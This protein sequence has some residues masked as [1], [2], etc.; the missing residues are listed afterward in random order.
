MSDAQRRKGLG[1][2][3][4]ALIDA[5]A[6]PPPDAESPRGP[7]PTEIAVDLIAPNPDQPRKR[8]DADE[9]EALATSIREKGVIQPLI[10]RPSAQRDGRY[11]IVAGERR[12]R[13]AQMAR[14]HAVPAIVRALDDTETLEIALLE[15]VQRADLDPI[16][17]AAGYAQL[18][19]RYGHTQDRLAA[20]V[21]KSRSHIANTLR[22]LNLPEDVR[23]LLQSGKLTA[24]HARAAL[25][26]EDPGA[27]ARRAADGGWTVR[28]TE[29]RAKAPPAPKATTRAAPARKDA[30]TAALEA[31]LSAALGLPVEI[32]H[33]ENG[34]GQLVLR[35]RSLDDLDG[36]CRLLSGG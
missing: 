27:L 23:A 8:F 21:G 7:G 15:N 3:L 14:L 35:Y 28:E 5:S 6:A 22:L 2:G 4:A 18:I 34:D 16:E 1:R 12:W 25:G 13:A 31:D 9:L 10:L 33:R 11:E 24:G 20:I 32:R 29:R 19:E 26:A 36:L 17:E 30:D